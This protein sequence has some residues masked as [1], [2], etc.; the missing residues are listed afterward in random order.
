MKN[1]QKNL[2]ITAC[3]V[4]LTLLSS[5]ALLAQEMPNP[6]KAPLLAD[7]GLTSSQEATLQELAAKY[8]EDTANLRSLI[9]VTESRIKAELSQEKPSM[10]KLEKFTADLYAV[11]QADFLEQM[12]YQVALAAILSPSER[13]KLKE[14]KIERRQKQ[15]K[16]I[17]KYYI[18]FYSDNK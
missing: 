3:T 4:L 9:K 10:S 14:L 11:K 2:Q 15:D 12:K 7:L 17:D 16:Y 8:S 18:P 5:S 6:R 13:K 1:L